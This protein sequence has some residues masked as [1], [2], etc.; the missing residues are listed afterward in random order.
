MKK[1]AVTKYI[2]AVAA[3]AACLGVVITPEYQ[4]SITAGFLA[5]YSVFTLIQGK[6][7]SDEG[8]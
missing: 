8:K 5:L 3:V 7:K 1:E 4:E 2:K 6:F